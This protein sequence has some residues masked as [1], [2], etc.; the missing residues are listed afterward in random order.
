M[1]DKSSF[2]SGSLPDASS[3]HVARAIRGLGKTLV[4]NAN[5]CVPF[6]KFRQQRGLRPGIEHFLEIEEGEGTPV[7]I[8]CIDYGPGTLNRMAIHD[9]VEYLKAPR[10]KNIHVRW[11]NIDG[12]NAHVVQKIQA[13]FDFH[14]LAAEDVMNPYERTK[15]QDYGN[16]LFMVFRQIMMCQKKW[17]NEQVS[18][19]LFD[20]TLLTF[21]EVEGDLL[22]PVRD[23]LERDNS[24]FRNGKADY[25]MYAILDCIMDSY[26]PICEKYG[27]SLD[28]LERSITRNPKSST[29]QHLFEMKRDLGVLRRQVTPMRDLL[30]ALKQ[31]QTPL[32]DD[33]VKLFLGDAYEHSV[34]ILDVIEAY[35]DTSEALTDLFA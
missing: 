13:H 30:L 5:D 26:F 15:S 18:I 16:Y 27:Q 20:D 7:K 35:H 21:Q 12:L 2:D 8:T 31:S 14:L 32:I 9:L 34:Q 28:T 4:E 6:P 19:F 17:I 1:A 29:R 24:R 22:E 10:P 3:S 33:S 23:R 11:I 25:L